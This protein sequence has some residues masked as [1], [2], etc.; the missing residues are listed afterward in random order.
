MTLRFNHE[1]LRLSGEAG[2]IVAS[3]KFPNDSAW[4]SGHFPDNP[5]V[6][7]VALIALVAEAV[8]ERERS[9][10]RFPVITGI[11]RVRF[12]LPVRPDD[13]VTLEATRISKKEGPAY[14]FNVYLAGENACSGILTAEAARS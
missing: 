7:G 6:P 12:R 1:W 9:E 4:F 11:R 3:A 2:H 5:I 14:L 8:R 10:G 13:E